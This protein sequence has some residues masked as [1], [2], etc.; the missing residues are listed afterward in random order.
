MNHSFCSQKQ[1]LRCG[2][3]LH[4]GAHGSVKSCAV[5]Q[6]FLR[7]WPS[8]FDA[9]CGHSST[10]SSTRII[11]ARGTNIDGFK[12]AASTILPSRLH[13]LQISHI[14]SWR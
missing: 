6:V 10:I 5:R 4:A 8:K 11:S 7:F 12:Y 2:R 14:Y 13:L 1:A 9:L 3:Y